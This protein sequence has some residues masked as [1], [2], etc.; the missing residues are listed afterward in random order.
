[1]ISVTKITNTFRFFLIISLILISG[2]TYSQNFEPNT[3]IVKLKE[4]ASSLFTHKSET[5]ISGIHIRNIK[6]ILRKKSK[7]SSSI[8]NIY[9][10]TI[11]EDHLVK[12][13][14]KRLMSSKYFEYCQ[15]NFYDSILY[16][17][18]DPKAT[19]Q[20]A[21]NNI[22]ALEAWDID[23]GDSTIIIGVSDTGIN[24][25]HEDLRDNIAYNPNDP[26]DGVDNDF[27]GYI[28][29]YMGWDFGSNDNNPQWNESGTS[30][31]AIHGTFSAGLAGADTDNGKGMASVGFS[32]KILPI[33]ISNNYGGMS[34]GYESII[35]AAEH[36]CKIINCSWGNT[37]P[38]D[39]GRDV[40][41][42]VTE[43]LNVIVVSAAGN[44]NNEELF[45]PASYDNVVSVAATN[46]SD[47]K[48][49][50]SS[51]NWRV[52][53]SAPGESVLSTLSNSSYG[54]S[55]GTSF[56]A[57]IVSS[58]LALL[59]SY[60]PDTMSNIQIIEI[61]KNS[62]DYIDSTGLNLNYIN[63]LGKGRVNV[64]RALQG[65][66]GA[67][68]SYKDFNL[69]KANNQA[70]AGDTA[71]FSG[72]I[73]NYL[74][75]IENVNVT[76]STSS[77]FIDI[78]DHTFSISSI[79][80]NEEFNI[81]NLHLKVII[82][83]DIP[84]NETVEFSIHFNGSNY[85]NY[86]LKQ[87][88]LPFPSIVINKNR[89]QTTLFS[90]GRI[91]YNYSHNGFGLTLDSGDDILYEMG[92]VAGYSED[93]TIANVR[94]YTDF[95]ATNILDSASIENTWYAKNKIVNNSVLP[96][97]LNTKYELFDD[98][99]YQNLFFIHQQ[100]VNTSDENIDNFFLGVFADWDIDQDHYNYTSIDSE[101]A[102]A[103]THCYSSNKVAGIQLLSHTQWNRYA[104]D[105]LY[106]NS[107][108]HSRDGLT[109]PELYQ[110][111]SNNNYYEG[112]ENSGTDILDLLSSGPFDIATGDTLELTFAI[113]ADTSEINILKSG[114]L[115]QQLFDSLYYGG[116][117]IVELQSENPIQVFPNPAQEYFQ[118]QISNIGQ[119]NSKNIEIYNV[120]GELIERRN[121]LTKNYKISTSN[122]GKGLYLVKIG[123]YSRKIL[124]E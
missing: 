58:S 80:E 74:S 18:S 69:L 68:L 89:I 21:L 118:I 32:N 54:V 28:D 5:K 4:E 53:I 121:L 122:W 52:D 78:L 90:E 124:I 3:L 12:K 114:K 2:F 96:L 67:A 55:S 72:F 97:S 37:I 36:G 94:S 71:E 39:Y 86:E 100:I 38:H 49:G 48:W 84:D 9:K 79:S 117:G 59:L 103:L 63:K 26:I 34:T 106:N 17:P 76:I 120:S 95:T 11:S 119:F 31:N 110:A 20:Y 92:V 27:D 73:I 115:A 1:M 65:D 83:E 10:V 113:L 102:L 8:N 24:F 23:K 108:I 50:N 104:I 29:N 47:L 93:K 62:S 77:P 105:N 16:T 40:I 45:Y 64:L 6:P 15:P 19:I 116:M 123:S 60:Y 56:A 88:T 43:D 81:N 51:Y 82:K 99:L 57:P 13:S 35:Y 112:I 25:D 98:S 41:K 87:I 7:S 61:L 46:S 107:P 30:G 91:A 42:Y 44:D 111:L 101:L 70:Y 85:L 109:R 22:K 33:K 14:C 75:S 66:F